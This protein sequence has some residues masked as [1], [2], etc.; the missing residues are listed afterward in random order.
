MKPERQPGQSPLTPLPPS[1]ARPL[2]LCFSHLRWNFVWQRPQQLMSRLARDYDVA[3]F[4]EPLF[5]ERPDAVLDT[6]TVAEGVT[7]LLPRLP[8]GLDEAQVADAQRQLLDT[9]LA[10]QSLTS[11]LLWYFTPMSMT[12]SAHLQGQMVIFDCM[13]ELSAFRH[14]PARLT[15]LEHELLARADVVFAGGYSLWK[16]RTQRH[17]NVHLLPSGV[18]I[19]HFAKAREAQPEPPDQAGIGRPRLGYFGVIDERL[20]LALLEA[21]A[22]QRPA[23]QIVLIG[24]VVKIDPATLP[25]LANLHYLGARPYAELPAYL[26]GWEVALMPF[27]MNELTRFISPTKAPEYL[28][29]GRPVV[30]TP[31]HDVLN[32]FD[33][34]GAVLIG[35]TPDEFIAAAEAALQLAREPWQVVEKVDSLIKNMSWDSTCELIREQIECQR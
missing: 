8:A 17:G 21:L 34:N 27:A 23:W 7:V 2:L 4:E 22:R 24:P 18:D 16:S 3:F 15:E 33:G 25:R 10:P 30:S 19:A 28:A 35:A 20:D 5:E 31:I 13:D 12:F 9:W 1:S 32:R 6:Q 14:A 29:G 26:A 11:L